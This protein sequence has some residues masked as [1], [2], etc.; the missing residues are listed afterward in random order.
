MTVRETKPATFITTGM[1]SLGLLFPL[2][3]VPTVKNH[4]VA[5]AHTV[6]PS[7][8]TVRLVR[9]GYD[10]EVKTTVATVGDLLREQGITQAPEDTISPSTDTPLTDGLVISYRAAF[11]I[12]VVIGG[13]RQEMMTSAPDV[14]TLL[15]Q[16]EILLGPHD[17]ILPALDAA[18]DADSVVRISHIAQWTEKI[19]ERVAPIVDHRLSFALAPTASKVV[20]AGSPM[21]REKLVRF[22]R[23]DDNPHLERLVLRSR[24]IVKGKPKIVES[25]IIAYEAY[26]RIVQRGF[27]KTMRLASSA[28]RMVATAYTANC[29]GCSGTTAIGLHAGH[30]IVAVDPRVIPLGTRLY[31]PGYGHALA[32]DTGGAIRGHRIDLGFESNADAML[33]GRREVQVYVLK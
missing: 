27:Q 6:Q 16:H 26:A 31:I 23:V 7:T 8:H 11:K 18:L 12:S 13:A 2:A 24:V 10:Q 17:R 29:Y 19:R 15:S 20:S 4:I 22:R 33:F 21:V 14:A 32:G 25:G 1:L 30:G 5:F 3:S 9:D 28:F